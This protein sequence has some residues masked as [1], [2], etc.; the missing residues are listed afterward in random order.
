MTKAEFEG[1][2]PPV[3]TIGE[4]FIFYEKLSRDPK[5]LSLRDKRILR[6]PG[7]PDLEVM[8]AIAHR[9]PEQKGFPITPF[10]PD[11]G[12]RIDD[13]DGDI[14]TRTQKLI[15]YEGPYRA[16]LPYEKN[17]N[18]KGSRHHIPHICAKVGSSAGHPNFQLDNIDI[19]NNPEK[20]ALDRL[21]LQ[22][23]FVDGQE[24]EARTRN[25]S[26]EYVWMW[27]NTFYPFDIGPLASNEEIAEGHMLS[28]KGVPGMV[29]PS[30]MAKFVLAGEGL[31]V[32][33]ER[34]TGVREPREFIPGNEELP[35]L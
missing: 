25:D 31:L 14:K 1:P 3:I 4:E 10:D 35:E 13:R 11:K 22:I 16:A 27:F 21:R 28:I 9:A 8:C 20:G 7:I 24:Y 17:P 12:Y 23:R 29:L 33:W 19:G 18:R 15:E 32:D 30:I 6:I 2:P 26:D 5:D 34:T